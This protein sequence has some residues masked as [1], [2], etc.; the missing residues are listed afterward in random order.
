MKLE[1]KKYLDK[2]NYNRIIMDLLND[3]YSVKVK[4]SKDYSTIKSDTPFSDELKN[5]TDSEKIVEIVE[6]FLRN[7]KVV[8]L[9]EV[10]IPHYKGRYSIA[11]TSP[12]KFLAVKLPDNE[13]GKT[14]G[15]RIVKK[16][17][18]DR[19]EYCLNNDITNI[20]C[21]SS[22]IRGLSY[23]DNRIYLSGKFQE[24][25]ENE[26]QFLKWLILEKLDYEH[27]ARIDWLKVDSDIRDVSY[28][29]PYLICG[30]NVKILIHYEH[31]LRSVAK[32]IDGYNNELRKEKEKQLVLKGWNTYGK[33][34]NG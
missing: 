17:Y 12:D 15:R 16:Y 6:Y 34:Y 24:L 9:A 14:I 13:L 18:N 33:Y 19:K 23:G 4:C 3:E 27:E 30:D 7:N 26:Y 1:G 32:I 11:Y 5:L 29:E 10:G 2:N 21:A 8:G 31:I 25:E 28:I 22:I 20:S